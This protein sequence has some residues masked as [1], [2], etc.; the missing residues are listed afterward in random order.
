MTKENFTQ[1]LFTETP[2]DS[3]YQRPASAGVLPDNFITY[4][5]CLGT[6]VTPQPPSFEFPT[7]KSDVCS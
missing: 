7:R 4:S 6:K 5:M 2:V 1:E 3:L